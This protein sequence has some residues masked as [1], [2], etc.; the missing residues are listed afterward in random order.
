M[1]DDE[2]CRLEYSASSDRMARC[3]RSDMGN[4]QHDGE[5]KW[6]ENRHQLS[7]SHSA[8]HQCMQVNPRTP[9]DQES[10]VS[11]AC[12]KG[13]LSIRQSQLRPHLTGQGAPRADELAH[14]DK[15]VE[16]KAI[17]T[18][19]TF[20]TN[21]TVDPLANALGGCRGTWI[22]RSPKWLQLCSQHP[23]NQITVDRD[24][25]GRTSQSQVL[26]GPTRC[27]LGK[28]SR[29]SILNH[30]WPILTP[31]SAPERS[32]RHIYWMLKPMISAPASTVIC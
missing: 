2:M 9:V 25:T 15:M 6:K 14:I 32:I 7:G 24:S 30:I 31:F 22:I 5:G 8:V 29:A 4:T 27:F 10:S 13:I 12:G 21:S 19:K 17:Y 3:H 11:A 16:V 1:M 20:R 23:L 18:T 26:E 28:F